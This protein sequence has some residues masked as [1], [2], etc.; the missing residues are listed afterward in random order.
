MVFILQEV[1]PQSS[2]NILSYHT[3]SVF[4]RHWTLALHGLSFR[5]EDAAAGLL[6]HLIPLRTSRIYLFLFSSVGVL[7]GIELKTSSM[8]SQHST[9]EFWQN[10]VLY[11]YHPRYKDM[12]ISLDIPH[13]A[14]SCLCSKLFYQ[15]P[16]L[17]PPL[18]HFVLWFLSFQK[19]QLHKPHCTNFIYLNVY[20]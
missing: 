3:T 18:T 7:P 11:N 4:T 10:Y 17:W 1:T 14:P 20:I 12:H 15:T 16:S 19:F 2:W 8:L 6:E 5:A 13:K 9:N